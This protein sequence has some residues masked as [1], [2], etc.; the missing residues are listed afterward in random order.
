MSEATKIKARRNY[1]ESQLECYARQN[2]SRTFL[3]ENP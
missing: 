3:L 2:Q 1:L